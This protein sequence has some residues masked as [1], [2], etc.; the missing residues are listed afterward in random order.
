MEE[1]DLLVVGAGSGLDVAQTA[2]NLG[3]SVAVVERDALGGTCLN[4]G[5]IPSK[6]L[7]QHAQ[8]MET[9]QS[10]D[11]FGID[12]TV[13]D[14]A[15]GEFVDS[16]TATVEADAAD[17]R[18]GLEASQDHRLFEGEARFV[19]DRTVTVHG[20]PDDGAQ[21]RGEDVLVATGA[22]PAVPSIDGIA[23]VDYLTSREA[24][25]LRAPPDHLLVVGGGYIAAELGTFFERFG[26]EVT[27]VGR[28]PHM[29]PG[30]DD[31]VSHE[32]TEAVRDRFDLRVG[33]EATAV[34]PDGDDITLRARPYEP[35]ADAE[36]RATGAVTV[37][38]DELLVAA[39]R[40]PNTEA[41]NL[42]ATGVETTESG[43]V[44]VDEY[45]RTTAEGVWALGDVAGE[46]MLKHAAN[47]EARMAMLNILGEDLTPAD[48]AAMPFAVFSAPE[49][50]GVGRTEAAV[51]EAGIDYRTTRYP[52]TETA[53]GEAM[54]AEGFVKVIADAEDRIL[55]CHI[56]GPEA[57][58][59]I[60]E[61]VVAMTA[62]SGTVGDI[63]RTVH[64]HPALSEV[65]G[66]AFSGEFVPGP[67]G[68][69]DPHDLRALATEGDDSGGEQSG[70]ADD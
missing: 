56:V 64:V 34:S 61:V 63:R 67:K 6:M 14:V 7:V 43:F 10:A 54:G 69:H 12:V 46:P 19:D 11:E 35:A 30:V 60:Q 3:R 33:Y 17:I 49:V 24:L 66:R 57:A 22:R 32:F 31:E 23:E 55:G 4:R 52:Y 13:E 44:E 48:P 53:R 68:G 28:R 18:E 41:L 26:S 42:E 9:V 39:G 47:R 51:A 5:C 20:G 16:V 59:L 70:Q 50:A 37:T 29:L 27:V 8:V 40:R 36:E 38:G 21:V 58:V 1:F 62:G 45:L 15:F 2:A 25:R 65:V